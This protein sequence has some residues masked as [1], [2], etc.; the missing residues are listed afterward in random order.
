EEIFTL[1]V[2]STQQR[3]ITSLLSAAAI[4]SNLPVHVIIGIRSDFYSH[5]L[6]HRDLAI[7]LTA[8]QFNVPRMTQE[9]L[10]ATIQKSLALAGG[11]LDQGLVHSLLADTG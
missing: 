6:N 4:E 2:E 10:R 9:R 3:Y 5:C 8:N 11:Y 7:R 1:S